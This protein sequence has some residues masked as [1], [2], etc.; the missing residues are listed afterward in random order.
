MALHLPIGSLKTRSGLEPVR[1]CEPSTYCAIVAGST[2]MLYR[3][4]Y[5]YIL[6]AINFYNKQEA[7]NRTAC[8]SVYLCRTYIYICKPLKL[9]SVVV[10]VIMEFTRV[11]SLVIILC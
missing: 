6:C 7:K 2:A 11:T 3:G 1:R 5:I 8:G 10:D 4:I 9:I